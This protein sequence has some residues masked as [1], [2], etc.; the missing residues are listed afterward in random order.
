MGGNGFYMGRFFVNKENINGTYAEIHGEDVKHIRDVLRMKSGNRIAL[1]DGM[2]TDYL[3]EIT[4]SGTES[5]KLRILKK[6][7]NLCEPPV[8][9]VLFQAVPKMDR[10]ELVIQKGVEL[11]ISAVCPMITRYTVV[12][13]GA[14]SIERKLGR[15]RRKALEA[16]KQS[17]RGVV[18]E[19]WNPMY[20]REVLQRAAD[21]DKALMPCTREK[22]TSLKKAVTGLD[23]RKLCILIGPEGGFSDEEAGNAKKNGITPVTLGPRILRSE[24]AGLAVTAAVMYELGGLG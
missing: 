20:F 4:G 2:S 7:K 19:I 3:A 18:P 21:F 15:W 17:N 12:R 16:A 1:C 6:Q 8:N 9:I 11:G 23:A 13:P 10:M 22:A 24:T 14:G 5:I